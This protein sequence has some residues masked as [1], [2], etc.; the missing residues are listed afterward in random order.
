LMQT[1]NGTRQKLEELEAQ[2]NHL[3]NKQL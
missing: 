3:K 1:L 2:L